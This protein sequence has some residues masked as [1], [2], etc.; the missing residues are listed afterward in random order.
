MRTK[1]YNNR[2]LI[3]LIGILILLGGIVMAIINWGIE[4]EET[5]SGALC[6]FGFAI[7]LFSFSIKKPI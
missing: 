6:G 7:T 4:P 5:I 3:T 2:K 1:I